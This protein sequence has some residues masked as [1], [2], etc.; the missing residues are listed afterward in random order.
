MPAKSVRTKPRMSTGGWHL[1]G[2]V[3]KRPREYSARLPEV[4]L[5][6]EK[7]RKIES[8]DDIVIINK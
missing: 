3:G 4:P 8:T 1:I 5:P 2:Y 7:K 6:P